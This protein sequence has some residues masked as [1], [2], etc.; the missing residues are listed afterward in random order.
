MARTRKFLVLASV[1]TLSACS[2]AGYA[3][4]NYSG[5]DVQR[6]QVNGESWRIFDKP[7]ENRLMITPSLGRAASVGAVQGA[8]FGIS[9][10][11]KDTM[12]EFEAAADAY[13]QSRKSKC[14]VTK[15]ALV[16]NP[17]YEFFYECD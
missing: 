16:I 5:V 2:G 3:I 14:R 13:V 12:A 8:T 17:Q 10:G 11:G 9:D 6:I 7:N 4:E 15:G 1:F